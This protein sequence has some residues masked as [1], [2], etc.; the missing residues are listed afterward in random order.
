[1][2]YS[3]PYTHTVFDILRV[4]IPDGYKY[5]VYLDGYD[6]PPTQFQELWQ[7]AAAIRQHDFVTFLNG[8]LV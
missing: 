7:V 8:V 2:L 5:Q 3:A 4:N 6:A 1:M